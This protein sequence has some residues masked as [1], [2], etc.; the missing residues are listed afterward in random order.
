MNRKGIIFA[1]VCGIVA[2]G[3]QQGYKKTAGGLEYKIIESHN[4]PK[5][6]E[7]EFIKMHMR[8]TADTNVM[9][10]TYAS[11]R[12]AVMPFKASHE[13]FDIME[14][15]A[16]LSAGDSAVF[17]V[18]ADSVLPEM[19]RP[20]FIKK[21]D[22]LKVGLKIIAIETQ[23]QMQEDAKREQEEAE[24]NREKQKGI[25]DKLIQDYIA[26]HN[27][28]ATKKESGVYVVVKEPGTGAEIKN[29]HTVSLDYVGK[30]MEGKVFDTNTDTTKG[31]PAEPFEF[32]IGAT[33]MTPGFV[34]GVLG[35]KKNASAT[36]LI[37]SGLGY[38]A[39]GAP[40]RI[41]PNQILVFD[42]NI[43]D[44]KG[45]PKEEPAGAK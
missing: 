5:P 34:D 19:Q 4:G 30:D 10:D 31:Q 32:T 25:D 3:C 8:V 43:R 33:P 18:S 45:T 28:K 6:K 37:P 11:G 7:G 22:M 41:Q 15:L 16:Q 12:P 24:Q 13:R 23:A 38:G 21:G 27:L 9:N 20:P 42:I 36:L 14:V 29:G 44:V 39:Q 1:L 17:Q 26:K 35:L 40:P 2:A